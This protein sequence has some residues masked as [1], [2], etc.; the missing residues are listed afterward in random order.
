[1]ETGIDSTKFNTND[2][3][4]PELLDIYKFKNQDYFNNLIIYEETPT[5]EYIINQTKLNKPD[6]I[7]VDYFSMIA[8]V[9][10][11]HWEI[12]EGVELLHSLAREQ[13]IAIVCAEQLGDV[14]MSY[15]DKAKGESKRVRVDSHDGDVR[16]SK[17]LKYTANLFI[18][19][20]HYEN[21]ETNQSLLKL[22]VNK[23]KIT[24]YCPVMYF[25]LN[26]NK[27]SYERITEE[28]Y[29]AIKGN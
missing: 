1:M 18:S 5:I 2:F 15:Y 16:T 11:S 7:Y 29:C 6:I 14:Y 9:S 22:Q 8:F 21:H 3:T 24:P 28:R 19:L 23:N 20:N 26:K 17:V 4:D 25:E 27:L 13:N 12:K 10:Y